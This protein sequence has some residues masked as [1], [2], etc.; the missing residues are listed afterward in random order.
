M[1][2]N[3]KLD[4]VIKRLHVLQAPKASCSIRMMSKTLKT[5]QKLANKNLWPRAD[6]DVSGD[7]AL[8]D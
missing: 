4:L 7:L 5:S 3:A 6:P 1:D 2:P 8:H